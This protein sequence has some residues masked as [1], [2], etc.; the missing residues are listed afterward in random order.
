MP[1]P[2]SAAPAQAATAPPDILMRGN[3]AT[4]NATFR[5]GC[6]ARNYAPSGGEA[7]RLSLGAAR[8]AW[9]AV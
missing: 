7:R 5:L 1:P 3:A 2:V 8:R 4:P 6:S 9:A